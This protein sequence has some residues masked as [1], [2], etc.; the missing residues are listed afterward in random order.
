MVR[1]EHPYVQFSKATSHLTSLLHILQKC[2]LSPCFPEVCAHVI[3]KNYSLTIFEALSKLWSNWGQRFQLVAFLLL[4]L[5]FTIMHHLLGNH[6]SGKPVSQVVSY[7]RWKP[8]SQSAVSA[9]SN[10]LSQIVKWLLASTIGA[11]F[12]QYFWSTTKSYDDWRKL[13]APLAA[14]KGNPFTPSAFPTWWRSPG[15]A[16]SAFMMMSMIFIPIFVPGSIRVV[17]A[18]GITQP[19]TVDFPN[20]SK[21]Y[22]ATTYANGTVRFSD[23]AGHFPAADGPGRPLAP[24]PDVPVHGIR[25][26]MVPDRPPGEESQTA[27]I[28]TTRTIRKLGKVRFSNAMLVN[29]SQDC[30]AWTAG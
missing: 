3:Y 6:L 5:I 20:I 19:C 18:S 14:A 24:D 4:G 30:N 11:A 27:Y 7:G 2:L 8:P 16:F 13:D 25:P 26:D 29:W 23:N 12:V 1:K 17:T 28:A 22:L 15:L 10:V 21:A 9:L